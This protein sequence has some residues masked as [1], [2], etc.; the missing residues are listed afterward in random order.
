M[1]LPQAQS[2]SAPVQM[3][4]ILTVD[5]EGHITLDNKP[6][7][8][9]EASR[10]MKKHMSENANAAVILQ[11]DKQTAHGQVVAVMDMLKSAGVK[12]LAIAAQ[13]KG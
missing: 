6:V 7:I 5:A 2:A 1:Q 10:M 13:Q 4:I 11:A 8:I 12:R 3:P 9:D